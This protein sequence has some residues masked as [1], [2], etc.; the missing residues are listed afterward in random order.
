MIKNR[1]HSVC[2]YRARG[3]TKKVYGMA[4]S[5]LSALAGNE[6][7]G[8]YVRT[9]LPQGRWADTWDLIKNN[10]FKLVIINVFTLLFFLPAAFLILYMRGVYI[11]TLG[12]LNP[13][14][15]NVGIATKI[16]AAPG[17]AES[18]VLSTDLLFFSALI[19]AGLVASVGIAGALYS[20]RKLILT[21]G[22]FT[23]KGYF[24]GVKVG[25]FNTA[26]PV[27]V[28]LAFY[29][30]SVV[31]SDWAHLSVAQGA[32]AGGPVTAQVFI[33]IATIV[34][35]IYCCWLLAVGI[36]YK[37]KLKYLL[38]NSLVLATGTI[39]QTLFMLA[40]SLI[41]VWIML[42]PVQFFTVLGYIVF[43]F[44]GFSFIALCWMAFA[45]WV[46]DGF[47]E[48]AVK[49]EKEAERAK[50]TPK[51]LEE[52]KREDE[53]AAALELLAAG[54]SELIGNPIKPIE[55]GI[56]VPEI[57]VVF[58]RGDISRVQSD[59]E[60]LSGS[61]AAYADEHKNDAKYVEYNKMFAEREKALQTP[62]KKGK[63]KQI[64]PDNLL[65]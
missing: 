52:A 32:G 21:H 64:S 59:R 35:G 16:P 26:L 18:I 42:I 49:T 8:D 6:L 34:V 20:V 29:F 55:D 23:V 51:Q 11:Q 31:V 33:I 43:L 60:T 24:H 5:K 63:K 38:K 12:S 50:M 65:K 13:L 53:K 17:L 7:T 39:I 45:Q 56:S 46:F 4:Q 9:H 36:S 22:Q 37:V 41:P 61:V 54:K 40:F 2:A 3:A 47:I 10:F 30:A 57:G 25:Y 15:A 44:I 14:A 27:T 62:A 19:V 28:F 48:P 1:L 58:G